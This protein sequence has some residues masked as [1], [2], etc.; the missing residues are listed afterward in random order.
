MTFPRFQDGP[1]KC[2]RNAGPAGPECPATNEFNTDAVPANTAPF[3]LEITMGDLDELRRL[4]GCTCPPTRRTTIAR[5]VCP[6]CGSTAVT[7]DPERPTEFARDIVAHRGIEAKPPTFAI[8]GAE[9]AADLSICVKSKRGVSVYRMIE[10]IDGNLEHVE[11]TYA[12]GWNGPPYVWDGDHPD[13]E[14]GCDGSEECRRDCGKRCEHAERRAIGALVAHLRDYPS[15]LR[16]VH[17]KIG[18]DGRVVAGKGP[19]CADCAKAILDAGIGGIW[20]FEAMPGVWYQKDGGPAET[21]P[22]IW[23]YYTA[24][25]FYDVTMATLGIYQVRRK[26]T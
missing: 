19:S 9:T 5:I 11:E 24:R 7:R 3:P 21:G 25:A 16:M 2:P 17:V 15:R 22:G 20:L 23:R 14:L 12:Q 8:V 13:Y 10:D 4:T 26:S 18:A 1:Y 6:K